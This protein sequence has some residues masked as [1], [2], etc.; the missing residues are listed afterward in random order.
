MSEEKQ[1]LQEELEDLKERSAKIQAIPAI[2]V[3]C[4]F[5]GAMVGMVTK[6]MGP[7][8]LT[9]DLTREGVLAGTVLGLLITVHLLFQ[10]NKKLLEENL[11]IKRGIHELG[12]FSRWI[13][14]QRN[15]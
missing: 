6:T 14:Q 12:D 4:V 1:A 10:E 7:S 13:S 8:F 15:I 9:P 5:V 3:I 11:K 2:F